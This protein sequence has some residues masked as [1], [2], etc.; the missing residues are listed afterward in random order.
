[1][2]FFSKKKQPEP[3]RAGKTPD[4]SAGKSERDFPPKPE[5]PLEETPE[6]RAEERIATHRRIDSLFFLTDLGLST[7][8]E[9]IGQLTEVR[10]LW[11]SRNKLSS[12][13]KAIGQLRQLKKIMAFSNGFEALPEALRPLTQLDAIYM[14][15]CRLATL[16]D[17]LGELR[18]LKSLVVT[19]NHLTTL[20]AS[21]GELQQLEEINAEDN[22]LASLPE[23]LQRL[24]KLKEL[25]LHGN[26]Q[27][28][29]PPEVLGP[30]MLQ[31]RQD[32]ATPA[33]PE[34]IL[35]Y[36][37]RIRA[38]ESELTEM[39]GV[40]VAF[41]GGEYRAFAQ[42][43]NEAKL[44]L[45]GRG[46][47]GKTCLVNR[48]VRNQFV[49]TSKTQGIRIEQWPLK[50]G[51]EKVKLHVWD[52]GGQE[53]MHATHQ[54]F[55]TQRSLYLLV[56]A[57]RAGGE[58]ADAEYWLQLV[59]SFGGDSPVIVV[60]NKMAEQSFDLDRR[61]L[62]AKYPSIRG[63]VRTE[64]AD[65]MGIEELRKVIHE[66]TDALKDLRV[67]FPASWVEIKDRLSG[68]AER[69][70]NTISFERYGT[71]CDEL[72][73]KDKKAQE[74]LAGYLH[75]LG[76]ALNYKDDPRLNETSVLSPHWVTNGIYS[77][78]NWP[79]LDER[80]G[81]LCFGDLATVLDA[82]AYP[83]DKHLFLL[84]LMRKF[85]VCFEYPDDPQRRYLVPQLLGKEQ[86]VEMEEFDA[87]KCLNFQYH[88]NIVPEGL[89]P[90]F[91]VRTHP[92]SEAGGRWRT[93]VVL[94]FEGNRA[95]VRADAQARKV[96]IS[97]NGPR[98]GRRRL[99]AVI[100]SDFERIHADIRKLQV[101]EMVPVPGEP[102]WVVSYGE[103]R[104]FERKGIEK[105]PR[106]FGPEMIEMDVAALLNGVDI[107]G[108][109]RREF[110]PAERMGTMAVFIS[111]SHKD[112]TLRAELQTHLKLLQREGAISVWTERKVGAGGEW[113]GEIDRNL[114]AA[115]I[116]L[117]LI[118]A[119][120]IASD[121]CFDL[122]M[123]RALARHDAKEAL[124]VPIFIRAVDWKSAPF[125]K[126]Q[127]LPKEGKPVTLWADR[128]SAWA[129][130]AAGI[131]RAVEERRAERR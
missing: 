69:G 106:V 116:V 80:A 66:E 71:L 64:C 127:G 101:D 122:E 105:V 85:E 123:Q 58:D 15:D 77:L 61:G 49:D 50:L 121:Y 13:P 8:P 70:E 5:P 115:E 33:D 131:R 51:K 11:I 43:L 10:E 31:V 111:Y 16:P 129:D 41:V 75:A 65:G 28:G 74:A 76:I 92:L 2:G 99:L 25:Y 83:R 112:E 97:V 47:V 110:D 114:E 29:I 59:A 118:S 23:S 125:A 102:D 30:T 27:L 86:A 17:W 22:Q 4:E 24:P 128:D 39:V 87:R 12:M 26:D 95:L 63:F 36:Y 60:L 124:V 45:I 108:S 14:G 18:S 53:I 48:L 9:S 40:S 68:M 79:A 117:L 120:F 84:D 109:R 42:P 72:G 73:E 7:L 67:P 3:E 93:G 6:A 130:V 32:N 88:Y 35:D 89:L 19:G 81:E 54:F 56:L 38:P 119:D 94:A 1:M 96:F 100:R 37:F 46:E 107:E 82:E 90:R 113:K 62:Q 55:L 91:I 20:P 44:I 98:E 78:L 104:V 103:L 57:G 126:L 34:A 21:I 52:F